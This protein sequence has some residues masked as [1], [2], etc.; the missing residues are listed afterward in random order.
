MKKLL[1]VLLALVM[2]FS[3]TVPALAA[4]PEK[5]LDPP[6]WRILGYNSYEE[7]IGGEYSYW[8][9]EEYAEE[10]ASVLSFMED[11]PDLTAQFRANAYSYF[12]E[13]FAGNSGTAQEYMAEYEETEEQ[14]I[15]DM[16]VWQIWDYQA[17]KEYVD[18]WAAT[19]AEQPERT[20]LFLEELP[21]WFAQRY[22]WYDS[23]E[24][25]TEYCDC[26][27]E[28]YLDLPGHL[29]DPGRGNFL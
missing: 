23:L 10:V 14:F 28:A 26:I 4:A 18:A 19:C 1:S 5:D 13:I 15:T 12:G 7:L 20:A 24:E 3:L 9:E 29:R 25:Y 6:L 2:V 8:T 21:T 22:P 17:T 27:E 11:N 16:T